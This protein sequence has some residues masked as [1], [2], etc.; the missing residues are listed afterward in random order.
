MRIFANIQFQGTPDFVQ[1][2]VRAWAMDSEGKAPGV[3][4]NDSF[5]MSPSQTV[6]SI[7]FEY[8]NV[9]TDF[10]NTSVLTPIHWTYDH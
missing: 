8:R 2:V 4:Y 6:E 9:L 3:E 1:V 7:A 10:F 5:L